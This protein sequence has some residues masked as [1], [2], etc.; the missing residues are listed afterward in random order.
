MALTVPDWW[1]AVLLVLA[2]YR[3]TRLG[4][5]DAFPPAAKLRARLIG[6]EWRTLNPEDL[7]RMIGVPAE[8]DFDPD[9]LHHSPAPQIPLLP[10]KQPTSPVEGVRPGYSRPTLAHLVHCPFCLGWWVTLA[11]WVGFQA[12]PHWA[13]VALSPFALA[14]AVGLVGKDLD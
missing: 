5:W 4:G 12:S 8:A 14:G 10:G 7:G 9:S 6:E 1:E 3:L 13:L 2:A 11:C